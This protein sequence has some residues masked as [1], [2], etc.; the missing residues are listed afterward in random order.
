MSRLLAEAQTLSDPGS[1]LQVL[2]SA[3]LLWRGPAFGEYA[4]DEDVSI[5]AAHLEGLRISARELRAALLLAAGRPAEAAAEAAVLVS[6]QPLR[7]PAAEILVETL[8]EAGRS[9]EALTAYESYRT[10][11]AEELGADPGAQLQRLYLGI[12]RGEA[13]PS[14]ARA[15]LPRPVTSYVG[16]G[17]EVLDVTQALRDNR[18]MT[19]TGP[20][21]VGKTRLAIEV[22]GRLGEELPDGV[23]FCDL[24]AVADAH[25]VPA[26]VASILGIQ[27]RHDRSMIARLVEVLGGRRALLVVDNCEHV[28][29]AAAMLVQ[30]VVE[31]TAKVHVL[32]TS[33]EPLG[34][35]G[36][37]RIVVEP[38]SEEDGARLFADRARAARPGLALSGEDDVAAVYR[39]CR[40]VSGLPLGVELAAARAAA[41][42]PV[43]IAAD[44]A[45]RVDRLSATR[46]G[47]ARHRSV[48][49]V[50]DWSLD[51][52]SEAQRDLAEHLAVF[53]G[54]CTVESAA[55]VLGRD[56]GETSD[57]LVALVER[58]LVA[59]RPVR[60]HTRYAVLEPVRAR[61]EQRL[62]E[63]GLLAGARR[64]HATYFAGMT[65][66]ASARMRTPEAARWMQTVDH[67]FANLR[68]AC[69]WSMDADGGQT[70]LQLLAPLHIYARSSMPTELYEWAEAAC[71]A[72][73]PG[74]PSL[75]A[76]LA[77]AAH[78]AWR[79]G[80][81]ARAARLAERATQTEGSAQAMALAFLAFAEIPF[82]EG[83]REEAIARYR[84][85]SAAARTAEDTFFELLAEADIAVARAYSGDAAAVAAAD[86]VCARAEALDAP[87]MVAYASFMAGETRLEHSPQ[88]ALPL[89]RRAV[90]L[91][92]SAGDRFTTVAAG[93]SATSVE[94]RHGDPEAALA[95]LAGLL[96]EW[97]R[98][99]AWNPTWLTLRLCI[100]VFVWLGEHE[101]AAQLLGA[102]HASNTAS[103][104]YGADAKRI[105][106]AE[107]TLCSAL[108]SYDAL[109]SK[110]AAL[111]DDG[112]V[113]LAR[114]T[115]RSLMRS[116]GRDY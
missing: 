84:V 113:T 45:G 115:L 56:V 22:A 12:L 41:R 4:S 3:L 92:R 71:A 20:G 39:I 96:D 21:G 79:R 90:K 59:P 94:V 65:A 63:R 76:V 25:A 93:L 29:D 110:G 28:R 112:A 109:V 106:R 95:D 40:Q 111:G 13:D 87:L 50:V 24:S 104:A 46:S 116:A 42:T 67:E 64:A 72:A 47:P 2:D 27:R 114:H 48:A 53:A 32:A 38:L 35:P 17:D 23:W 18:L 77:L 70:A 36:E 44:L 97:Q 68:A 99:G 60:G 8:C 55:A 102:M 15:A 103:P 98:A 61:A 31:R 54:G 52:L 83:R 58:S 11:L 37:Q 6:E 1:A 9:S 62:R 81:L 89:L 82:L 57:L 78:G 101:S 91:A 100:D 66:R 69:R 14:R 86:E 19:L 75:P 49:A 30:Q 34:V 10:R 74:H 26:A 16:R 33:R 85:A 107:T 80:D 43:E 5:A 88:E 51:R 73:A 108:A 7:E 105:A